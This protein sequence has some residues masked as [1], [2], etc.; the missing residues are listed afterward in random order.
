MRLTRERIA[1]I[2]KRYR[3]RGWRV[4]ERRAARAP[5][6]IAGGQADFDKKTITVPPLD[7]VWGVAVFLHECGHVHL[8]HEYRQKRLANHIAEYEA[9]KFS[10]HIMQAEGI[11]RPAWIGVEAKRNVGTHVRL[12]RKA[13]VPID[14]KVERWSGPTALEGS[15]HFRRPK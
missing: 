5:Q 9:E 4:V 12:D 6:H 11:R 2:V 7:N 14:R 8:R 13:K 10:L 15:C 3:P 1:D